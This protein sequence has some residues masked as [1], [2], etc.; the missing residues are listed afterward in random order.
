MTN[1]L[2][3]QSLSSKDW[4][5][6]LKTFISSSTSQTIPPFKSNTYK[7]HF[8][9]EEKENLLNKYF[10]QQTQVDNSVKAVPYLGP[11]LNDNILSELVLTPNETQQVL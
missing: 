1:K 9:D 11:P 10:L 3:E 6:T 2:K 8:S 4:W 5:K 7:L